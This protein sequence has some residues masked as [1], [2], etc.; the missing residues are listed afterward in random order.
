MVPI[1]AER[2]TQVNDRCLNCDSPIAGSACYCDRCGQRTDTARLTF[3]D[4]V[5]DL[6]QRFVNVER[7][8][9]AFA[10][11]LLVRPGKVAREYV[12]GRR[13]RYYGPF[14][15]LAVLVGITAL[16]INASGFQVLWHDGLE[17]GPMRLLQRHFNL[18]LL[19][20][21]PLL[22]AACAVV[23][24]RARLTLPEHMVLVAYTFSVRAVF[25]AVVAPI[26]HWASMDTPKLGYVYAYWV[27]WFA[28][29]GWAAS[30]FYGG[31]RVGSWARGVL[32]GALGHAAIMVLL[33]MA[34]TAYQTFVVR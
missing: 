6:M 17:E 34:G 2:R 18:L 9:L 23:F 25:L 26:A 29:F 11:A 8:P 14:A 31:S 10:R 13:R 33:S 19:V 20:Q 15:T 28:Y 16:I 24:Y 27:V 5:R 21:L 30:Q 7:G 4:I 1:A 32:A 3:A 12:D 22:G